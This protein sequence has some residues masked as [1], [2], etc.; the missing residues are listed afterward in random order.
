M[1]NKQWCYGVILCGLVHVAAALENDANQTIEIQAD[2]M[3]LDESKGIT[4]YKG[5]VQLSQGS[6]SIS[7]DELILTS[8]Q[9]ELQR[10]N[11]TGN[12]E[13]P[14][15]FRQKTET[16]QLA[17]AQA[18][19]MDFNVVNS[20]LVLSGQA[21][22]KQ[23]S[24]FIRSERI[25]YNTLSNSLVAGKQAVDRKDDSGHDRVHIVITPEKNKAQD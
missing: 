13:K 7:A 9:G 1:H 3:T 12:T 19:Q 2:S 18:Q 24:S 8:N 4:H 10:M 21:E 16:G 20:H 5:N 25:E 6:I 14:A 15:L 11:I 23:G 17:N 22:L